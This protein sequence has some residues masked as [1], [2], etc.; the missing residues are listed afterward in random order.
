MARVVG[1]AWTS[2]FT[3]PTVWRYTDM[4]SKFYGR[5]LREDALLRGDLAREFGAGF[6]GVLTD[7]NAAGE[8]LSG[9]L[10]LSV[11]W[12]TYSDAPLSRC[13]VHDAADLREVAEDMP[14]LSNDDWA[15][16]MAAIEELNDAGEE[17]IGQLPDALDFDIDALL[18]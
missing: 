17:L 8:I 10:D 3:S 2:G 11:I 9:K 7:I 18:E 13:P 4:L 12:S 16:A 1:T 14:G 15:A 6:E 5:N